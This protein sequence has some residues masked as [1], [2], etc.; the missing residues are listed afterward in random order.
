MVTERGMF[1]RP[2]RK[3]MDTHFK[4]KAECQKCEKVFAIKEMIQH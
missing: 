3:F 4:V 2:K 1:K